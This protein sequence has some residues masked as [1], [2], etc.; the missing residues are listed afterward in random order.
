MSDT[1]APP[2][3][4]TDGYMHSPASTWSPDGKPYDY[5]LRKHQEEDIRRQRRLMETGSYWSPDGKP[6]DYNL[7]AHQEENLPFG[8]Q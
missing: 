2:T 1:P 8:G 4:N 5:N 6:Y 7:R 3:I